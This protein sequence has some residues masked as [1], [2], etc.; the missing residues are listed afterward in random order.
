M[1]QLENATYYPD[2]SLEG[3][4]LAHDTNLSFYKHLNTNPKKSKRFAGAMQA[5]AEG[6]DI[7]PSFLVES[8]PW[9]SLGAAKVVDL[10]GS[11]GTCHRDQMLPNFEASVLPSFADVERIGQEDRE[12]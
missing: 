12:S 11:N 10:G 5:F 9:A 1:L 3:Y 8:Y 6:P 4:S 7:N 2:S